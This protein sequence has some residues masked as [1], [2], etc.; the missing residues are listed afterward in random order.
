MYDR[1]KKIERLDI[2][3]FLLCLLILLELVLFLINYT[4]RYL[5]DVRKENSM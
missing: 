4:N 3:P 5:K 1:K 2:K